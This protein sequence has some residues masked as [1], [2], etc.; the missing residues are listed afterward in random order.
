MLL[1]IACGVLLGAGL[2][3]SIVWGGEELRVPVAVDGAA[4]ITTASSYRH[5]HLAGLR[6]YLWWATVFT[7]IGTASGILVTGAGGRLAMRVLAA[8]SPEAAGRFTEA[9]ASVGDITLVGTVAY[10][11]FGALPFAFASA[12]LYLLLA[13]WLPRGRLAGPTFGAVLLIIV[14]PIIDPLRPDNVDFNIVGPGWLSALLFGA[15]AV[16]QGALLAALA[17][18]LSRGL[19]L[20]SRRNWPAAAAPLLPAVILFPVGVVLS[21]AGI[22]AL[23]F[24]RLLPWFLELRAS[25]VGVIVGRILLAAAVVTTLPGFIAALV[26]I[27]G[28]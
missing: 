28:R 14:S 8:T 13:P 18:R 1:M 12:A 7:A 27:V 22:V 9:Q 21:A 20:I 16:L 11:I 10:L 24:P 5:A 4:S 26:S 3:L 15:L 17:G 19:P 2:A 6:L 25:R 23:A